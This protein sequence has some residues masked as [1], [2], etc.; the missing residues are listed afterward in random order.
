MTNLWRLVK[1]ENS[2]TDEKIIIEPVTRAKYYLIWQSHQ[3]ELI[4]GG[5]FLKIDKLGLITIIIFL[6]IDRLGLIA[7]VIFLEINRFELIQDSLFLKIDG[8][9]FIPTDIFW[10]INDI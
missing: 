1:S 9:E 2:N 5:L 10:E 8:L 3:F 4:Q 7:M 6:K